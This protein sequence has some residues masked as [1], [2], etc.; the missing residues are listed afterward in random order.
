MDERRTA[1]RQKTFLAGKVI[2]ARQRNM[3]RLVALKVSADRGQEPQTL[4]QLD[5]PN[6]VRV[7]DQRVIAEHSRTPPA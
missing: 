6:I 2:F 7:Y 1:R 4:A 3:Q 5:H